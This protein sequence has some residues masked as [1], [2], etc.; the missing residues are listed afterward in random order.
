MIFTIGGSEFIIEFLGVI[1]VFAA[2]GWFKTM[3]IG[4]LLF[5]GMWVLLVLAFFPSRWEQFRLWFFTMLLFLSM[6]LTATMSVR[7]VDH[8]HWADPEQSLQNLPASQVVDG[9]PLGVGLFATLTNV[10]GNAMTTAM[11]VFN[12]S[13]K[14]DT[15]P[16]L[17]QDGYLFKLMLI[18]E[19]TE[20]KISSPDARRSLTSFLETCHL[21]QIRSGELTLKELESQTDIWGYL[22]NTAGGNTIGSF[23]LYNDDADSD[24]DKRQS[25]P[26]TI[27]GEASAG[28]E[29]MISAETAFAQ[30]A[31]ATAAFGFIGKNFD[32]EN[33]LTARQLSAVYDRQL[34]SAYIYFN[35]AGREDFVAADGAS[36]QGAPQRSRLLFRNQMLNIISNRLPLR[37]A[38]L[39]PQ[40]YLR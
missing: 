36:V 40:R 8:L 12:D 21:P 28:L 11:E 22:L 39:T 15:F 35:K 20:A 25:F 4:M 30:S 38:R 31:L 13:E 7:V 10:M 18:A 26:C 37:I 19:L 24:A 33:P 29:T 6:L 16:R 3:T 27:G 5:S 32:Y 9:V 23:N 1:S 14:P 34:V 17:T 2:S